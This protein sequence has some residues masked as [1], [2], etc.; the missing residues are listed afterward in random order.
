MNGYIKKEDFKNELLAKGFYSA[1][2]NNI[3]ENMVSANVIE[4]PTKSDEDRVKEWLNS[5]LKCNADIKAIEKEIAYWNKK[6]KV[7]DAGIRIQELEDKK[8]DIMNVQLKAS[9]LIDKITDYVGRAIFTRRY[10]LYEKWDDIAD[11][12]GGMTV[13]NARNIYDKTLIEFI[14]LWKEENAI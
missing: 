3:L 1:D 5:L 6:N 9:K 11:A 12:L 14:R 13:R 2:I 8:Q 4:V 7:T 10:I